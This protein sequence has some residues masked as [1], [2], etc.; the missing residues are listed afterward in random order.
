MFYSS[1]SICDFYC[2]LIFHFLLL[3]VFFLCLCTFCALLSAVFCM[4]IIP[5]TSKYPFLSNHETSQA[6][7]NTP[8]ELSF[9]KDPV[10]CGMAMVF[11]LHVVSLH[12]S[13]TAKFLP[14]WRPHDHRCV[15][16]QTSKCASGSGT[17]LLSHDAEGYRART[18]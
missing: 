13:V 8:Q 9:Q 6:Y 12:P 11:V 3:F 10:L 15:K 7:K 17:R 18:L 4:H 5:L 16:Y 2:Y 14:E 1:V